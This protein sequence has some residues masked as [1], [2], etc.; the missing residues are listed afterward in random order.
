MEKYSFDH[1]ISYEEWKR[2][3]VDIEQSILSIA[4]NRRLIDDYKQSVQCM[5]NDFTSEHGMRD[6]LNTQENFEQFR[7]LSREDKRTYR[8]YNIA[9]NNS[10]WDSPFETDTY[11]LD[12]TCYALFDMWEKEDKMY[13]QKVL[14]NIYHLCHMYERI[15]TMYALYEQYKKDGKELPTFKKW[16]NDKKKDFNFQRYTLGLARRKRL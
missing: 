9:V 4:H 1:I 11:N 6:T 14:A 16:Y 13:N 8:T 10:I 3:N 2:V 7:A 5:Y 15:A 12:S